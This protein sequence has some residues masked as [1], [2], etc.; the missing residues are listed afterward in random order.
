MTLPYFVLLHYPEYYTLLKDVDGREMRVRYSV[1][2]KSSPRNPEFLNSA[3]K[4]NLIYESP[5]KIYVGNLPWATKPEDLRNIFSQ[6]GTVV[7]AK[8]L[9]DRKE[10]KTRAYGFLSFSSAAERDASIALDGT[11]KSVNHACY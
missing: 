8:V 1:E 3:P 7:S 2:M 11:V 6:L 4:K 5:Y 9:L 10:G